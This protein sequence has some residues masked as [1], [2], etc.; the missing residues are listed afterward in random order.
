M[1]VLLW[2]FGFFAGA[3]AGAAGFAAG[4]FLVSTI[5]TQYNIITYWKIAILSTSTTKKILFIT[6]NNS[7]TKKLILKHKNNNSLNKNA[8]KCKN[9]FTS[10]QLIYK[11]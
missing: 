1:R 8:T 2:G 4:F 6:F 11:P 7:Q 9:Y 10:S 3:A 5:L